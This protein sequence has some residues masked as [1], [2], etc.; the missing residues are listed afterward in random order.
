MYS[1]L[2]ADPLSSRVKILTPDGAIIATTVRGVPIGKQIWCG[3]KAINQDSAVQKANLRGTWKIFKPKRSDTGFDPQGRWL[4]FASSLAASV[5]LVFPCE[6][7]SDLVK[8]LRGIFPSAQGENHEDGRQSPGQE[9]QP[10]RVAAGGPG[11]GN[12]NVRKVAP[13][14]QRRRREPQEVTRPGKAGKRGG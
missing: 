14:V 11:K 12:R 9:A 1:I 10:D 4:R 5:D 13:K 3:L 8:Q 6:V 2:H 7:P